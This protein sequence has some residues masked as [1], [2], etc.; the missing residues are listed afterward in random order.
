[1]TVLLLL[2]LL[3]LFGGHRS[4]ACPHLCSCQGAQVD[5]SS[6]SLTSAS[7]PSSFPAGT[8]ELYLHDNLLSTLPN[9]LLDDLTSLH[10]ISLHGNPWIC[11]CGIL[12]LRAWLRHQ[13][14]GFVSHLGVNCSS[15]PNLRGRS[16]EYLTEDEVL[17]SC[18]YWYCNLALASLGSLIGFVA[19]QAALLVA[20]I[21]FLKKFERLSKEA[22]RTT[23]E[24][25]TAGDGQRENDYERL[26]D[27]SI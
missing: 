11:D 12:Y 5:C 19:V 27:S 1:M 10:F 8:T 16:V 25:F 18:H 23:E 17:E 26:K 21:I 2:C 6:R 24:S 9:G 3:L 14:I 13:P 22:K 7:M 15:P 4:L 20:L